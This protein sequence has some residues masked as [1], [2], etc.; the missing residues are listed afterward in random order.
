[1]NGKLRSFFLKCAIVESGEVGYH[2]W[3]APTRDITRLYGAIEYLPGSNLKM[4]NQTNFGYHTDCRI[5]TRQNVFA[6]CRKTHE[7]RHQ[8]I[9]FRTYLVGIVRIFHSYYKRDLFGQ[10]T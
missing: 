6:W 7:I 5:S 4:C 3:Q 8:Y 1:M 2:Q 10:I 9:T